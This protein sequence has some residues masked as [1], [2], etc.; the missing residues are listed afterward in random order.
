MKLEIKKLP[1]SQLELTVEIPAQDVE[2]Y[3]NQAA[4]NLS[5]NLKKPGF[6]PGHIPIKI[7]EQEIGQERFWQEA[8]S[9]AL[10][11][12]YVKIILDNKIEAIGLPQIQII[13]I[14]PK[15]PFIYKAIISVLPKIELPDYRKIK[16]KKKKVKVDQKEFTKLLL[17]LQKNRSK[18]KKVERGAKIGDAIEIDFKTYLNSI[19]IDNGESKNHPL[20]LGEGKF[21]LGFEDKLVGMRTGEKKEFVLRFP[22]DYHQKNLADRNVEF[23]VEMKEIEERI[24]P[25]LDDN[26]AKSLGE[27][28]DLADL[29]EKLQQNLELEVEQKEKDRLDLEIME[30]IAE[31]TD[32]ELPET[33]IQAEVR[34][35]IEELKNMVLVSG[36]EYEKYLRH[37]KKTEEDLKK[38][39]GPRAEKRVKIGLIL[40]EIAK[41]EKINVQ[42]E[43]VE[44][45][46][47]KTLERYQH[48]PKT[49]EKI[50]SEEYKDYLRSLI[51]NRKVFEFLEKITT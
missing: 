28:K 16:V 37:I 21:A 10:K 14:A 24:L 50:Q 7:V 32:F 43:E 34:K 39:F 42:E 29:K 25:N 13:K 35:M 23:R 30:K 3:F 11:K 5:Q 40:R 51:Q 2:K 36:G 19:P 17:N 27:F 6:R 38:D 44:K 12:S 26:F 47:K 48:D 46:Q 22:K 4:R 9:E 8:A 41:K 33:L 18:Y 20:I 45:E 31:K 1:Q 15:N 49:M